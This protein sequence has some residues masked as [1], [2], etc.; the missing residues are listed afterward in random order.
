VHKDN[1]VMQTSK[2]LGRFRSDERTRNE[3]MQ[4]IKG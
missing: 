2:M 4:L 1:V 3:F